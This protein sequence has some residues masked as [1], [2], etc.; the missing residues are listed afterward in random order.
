MRAYAVI[1]ALAS[2]LP[3]VKVKYLKYYERYS[4]VNWHPY[5]LAN[6]QVTLTKVMFLA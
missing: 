2:A 1:H 4:T 5:P 3:K 6:S